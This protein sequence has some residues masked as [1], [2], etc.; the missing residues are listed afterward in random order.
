MNGEAFVPEGEIVFVFVP[1]FKRILITSFEV[2]I[3]E[4]YKIIINLLT[5]I[6]YSVITFQAARE[7]R[8][9]LC[10][11]ERFTHIFANLENNIHIENT[12]LVHDKELQQYVSL[13]RL[14]KVN[15]Y[16][17]L[18]TNS[19]IIMTSLSCNN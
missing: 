1:Y 12:I 13:D 4:I 8:A 5:I 7:D 11:D 16:Y 14:D 18:I 3:C 10:D 15:V 19:F 17:L 9:N 2:S 6:F